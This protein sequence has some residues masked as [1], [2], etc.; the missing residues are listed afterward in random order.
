MGD[1]RDK[2]KERLKEKMKKGRFKLGEGETTLRILP[3]ARGADKTPFFEYYTHS[4]VGPNKRFMRCGKKIDD[5]GDCWICDN[6]IPKL[7]KS[8]NKAKVRRA[9]ALEKKA[10]FVVQIAVLDTDTSKYT[11][12]FLWAV[13]SG[14]AK[15]LAANVL[16]V[17]QSKKRD[18][19][20]PKKGY[21]LT[22]ERTGTGK[23]DTRY[24]P[25]IPDEDSSK[26]PE[27]ILA[28]L[29]TFSEL[30]PGYSEE[31]QK[32]AYFGREEEEP[33]EKEEDEGT[34]KDEGDEEEEETEE[35]S[36]EEEESE[37]EEEEKPKGKKK[38]KKPSEDEEEEKPEEEEEEEGSSDEEEEEEEP[39]EDEEEEEKPKGKKKKKK[40]ADEEEEEEEEPEEEEE[41]EGS[42]DEEEEEEEKPKGKK[43][44]KKP[45]E[46]EEEDEHV[47]DEEEEEESEPE[48]EEE[49]PEEE[50]E[51]PKKKKKKG[52][53]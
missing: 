13:S 12:P 28:K 15:S 11:G 22:I 30:V 39:E 31:E 3:N 19:V 50:E 1:W 46:D 17:L 27:K 16:R 5:S 24:G 45:S 43:K 42:G 48:E 25:L 10:Q 33:D 32:A 18:Y 47:G 37:D 7:R 4:D 20:D 14:G 26:V 35:E 38:K 34:E 21:N 23:T 53:K 8:G 51:R 29:K 44:K 2:A 40:P 41:E 52:K 9:E 49:E 6:L 36:E